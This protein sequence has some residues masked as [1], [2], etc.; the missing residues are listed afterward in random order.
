MPLYMI[1]IAFSII[2]KYSTQG[3]PTMTLMNTNS[4]MKPVYHAIIITLTV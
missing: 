1:I 4:K 3:M 2:S